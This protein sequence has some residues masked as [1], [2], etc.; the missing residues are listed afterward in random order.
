MRDINR[1]KRS[2]CPVYYIYLFP[3]LKK[4]EIK[5][6]NQDPYVHP[7]YPMF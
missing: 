1:P 6:K 3:L 2:L 5:N 7:M 4:K